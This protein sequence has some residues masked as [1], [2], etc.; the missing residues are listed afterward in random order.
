[1]SSLKFYCPLIL[2]LYFASTRGRGF[3]KSN[4]LSLL[5]PI[6]LPLVLRGVIYS[7]NIRAESIDSFAREWRYFYVECL[8]RN[9]RNRSEQVSLFGGGGKKNVF[10]FHRKYCD[11]VCKLVE[12]KTQRN[13]FFTDG[14]LSFETAKI[15]Y[16]SFLFPFFS[17]SAF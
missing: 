8:K 7:E 11:I 9:R 4:S 14:F 5:E 6:K 17:F 10:T 2:H 15:F 12:W 16:S 3:S 1:M 13:Y